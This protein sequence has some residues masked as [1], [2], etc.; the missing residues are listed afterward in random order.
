MQISNREK[1]FIA[2]NNATRK[3]E[4]HSRLYVF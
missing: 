3:Y 2:V 4:S 1:T